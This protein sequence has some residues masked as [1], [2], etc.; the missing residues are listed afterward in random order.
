MLYSRGYMADNPWCCWKQIAALKEVTVSKE[1]FFDLLS[2]RYGF[3]KLGGTFV[4]IQSFFFGVK[5][6]LLL[7]PFSAGILRKTGIKRQQNT[8]I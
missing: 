4:K 6:M 5:T 7:S 8:H 2:F 1:K 3:W